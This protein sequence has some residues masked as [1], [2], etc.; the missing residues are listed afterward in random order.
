[1]DY[2]P[3]VLLPLIYRMWARIRAQDIARWMQ[4]AG[5]CPLGGQSKSAE[6][7]GL[8]LATML[9]AAKVNEVAA[10]GLALDFSKAYD[11]M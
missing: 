4:R 10:G 6:E 2:R 3:V 11:K 7:H 8:L 1:M 9:E 5:I